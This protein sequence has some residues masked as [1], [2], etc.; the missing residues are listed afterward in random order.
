MTG[1]SNHQLSRGSSR[2]R[3]CASSCSSASPARGS[4]R[5]RA[6]ISSRPRCCR[7]TSVAA[8]CRTTRTT[9]PPV[10]TRSMSCT[11]SRA[12]GWQPVG[13]RS[14]MRRTCSPRRA[15][16]L[17]ISLARTTCCQSRS[18]STCRRSCARSATKSRAD[19]TFGA[20]VLRRQGSDLRR[21]LR[22]LQREGFR[23]VH[24]LRTPE[25]VESASDNPAAAVQRPAPCSTDRS[26]R[27]A[28]FTAVAQSWSCCSAS[29]ATP[30]LA[31][32]T[33]VRSMQRILTVVP[34]SCS[35]TSS[36]A[37]PTALACCDSRWGWPRPATQSSSRGITRTSCYARCG[38]ETCRSLTGLRSRSNNWPLSQQNSEPPSTSSSTGSSR[39]T[40]STKGDSS[41]HTPGS[42]SHTTAARRAA[43]AA[44]RC[45]ATRRVRPTSTDFRCATPGPVNIAAARWCCTGTRRYRSW[46]GS[47]THCASIPAA[48]SVASFPHCAIRRRRSSPS[49]LPG[50]TTN[51][52]SLSWTPISCRRPSKAQVVVIPDVL[53]LADV[54]GRRV[55]E[56]SHHGRIT[57]AAENATAALEVM[58]RFAVD[59]RWLLY[60]PPTMSPV[61]TS[62]RPDVLEHP[63]EAFSAYRAEG[64][65]QVVC[66]EKHMGSRAV[67]LVC[68]DAA[69]AARSI[70]CTRRRGRCRLHAHRPTLLQPNPDR[71]AARTPQR[72]SRRVRTVG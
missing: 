21:G 28:M 61:A 50:S 46:N 30:F 35:V 49:R 45:T 2:F 68:R 52:Q 32:P 70:W 5:S 23:T 42:R 34:W 37:G 43:C 60:L 25:E 31:T 41:F 13:S 62:A 10:A 48:S 7:R 1:S 27:S 15:S 16:S 51:P 22:G 40:S 19:R 69:V 57:V 55:V 58:S 18:C 63:A 44:S 4:R 65:A 59:P 9:R 56:T 20:H 72:R 67:A 12:S 11:T 26:M 66:E 54:I 29:S 24:V 36:T 71:A 38:V 47:T 6:R 33:G 17:S 64:I 53:D 8:S 14:S 39:T 3:S